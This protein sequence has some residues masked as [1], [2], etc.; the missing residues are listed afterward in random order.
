MTRK[1]I[2]LLPCHF[3]VTQFTSVY[4]FFLSFFYLQNLA[5]HITTYFHYINQYSEDLS[6]LK[7]Q[8]FKVQT[9]F[10]FQFS[11][12]CMA[13]AHGEIFSHTHSLPQVSNLSQDKFF[14][15]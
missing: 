2:D 15:I 12:L 13:Q 4:S 11:F 1:F 8:P 10:V 6:Y 9:L 7:F 5:P 3:P 14:N